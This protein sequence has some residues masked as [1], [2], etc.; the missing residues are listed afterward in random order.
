MKPVY[1][2]F[3]IYIFLFLK[4]IRAFNNSLYLIIDLKEFTTAEPGKGRCLG[5]SFREFVELHFAVLYLFHYLFEPFN[6]LFIGHIF[7]NHYLF[8]ILQHS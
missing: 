3:K 1:E 4:A 8:F 5:E 6:S 2:D 7:H